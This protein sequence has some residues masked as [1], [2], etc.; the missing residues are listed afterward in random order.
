VTVALTEASTTLQ[1]EGY[2]EIP[3]ISAVRFSVI[4]LRDCGN[5]THLNASLGDANDGADEYSGT[6]ENL[7]P[8]TY[9]FRLSG[10]LY[11]NGVP[12]HS[13]GIS[14]TYD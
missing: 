12:G 1:L 2:V 7:P 9:E 8:G 3:A 11:G 13:I 14:W 4:R 5:V 6:L 10:L